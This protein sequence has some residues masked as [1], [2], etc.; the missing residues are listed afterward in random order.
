VTLVGLVTRIWAKRSWV[1]FSAGT[2][3]FSFLLSL[4]A[5]SAFEPA[6]RLMG[7]GEFD[8]GA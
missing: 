6:F 5:N 4:L 3:D 1:R 2:I 8:V 7:I